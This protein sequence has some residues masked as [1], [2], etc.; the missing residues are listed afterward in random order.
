MSRY[1]ENL[2]STLKCLT[3]LRIIVFEKSGV[4]IFRENHSSFRRHH[5]TRPLTAGPRSHR[6]PL[7]TLA[8]PLGLHPPLGMTGRIWRYA[9]CARGR[10]S[11]RNAHTG[12][13]KEETESSDACH[14]RPAMGGRPGASRVAVRTPPRELPIQVGA[15]PQRDIHAIS[16]NFWSTRERFK[17]TFN[18]RS[19]Q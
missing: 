14:V 11:D 3:N 6:F 1:F 13:E 2:W 8:V 12:T 4:C 9:A 17:S 5:Y 19:R 18:C 16:K 10:T 7:D 15:G